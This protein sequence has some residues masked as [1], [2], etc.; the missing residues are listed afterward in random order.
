MAFWDN[1]NY[2][3]TAP[4]GWICPVCGRVMSPSTPYCPCNGLGRR[5]TVDVQTNPSTPNTA[6]DDYSF[7]VDYVHRD[8][9]TTG[10]P[11]SMIR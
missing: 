6:R 8:S 9:T 5:V 11:S 10:N 2:D 4:M 7:Y 1:P 3:M